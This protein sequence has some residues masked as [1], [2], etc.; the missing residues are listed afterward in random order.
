MFARILYELK[1][2]APF[3]ALGTLS[4]IVIMFVL[5]NVR[6]PSSYSD[7]LFWVS[8][9]GHV[10]LSALVTTALYR[11]HSKA[12][13]LA[14]FVIGYVGSVGI[15]T[16]SDSLIPYVGEWLL[17][18][19]NKGVHVGFIEKWWLVNPVA[20][21]GILIGYFWPRTHIP[22][23]GHVFLSTWASLFHMTMALGNNIALVQLLVIPV[24]LFLAVWIPCCT[25]D[26]VFPMLFVKGNTTSGHESHKP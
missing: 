1:H 4:G 2:H 11:R 21:I 20:S 6:V 25:S 8:H 18:L 10:L 24:F 23:A 13:F 19:P 3:T 17:S 26:I 12:G 22:H 7:T 5:L 16:L 15:A 9:P 14:A